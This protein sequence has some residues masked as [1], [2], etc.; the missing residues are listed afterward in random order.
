ME[1]IIRKA[2]AEDLPAILEIYND[3]IV[4]TTA[5]YDYN[6]HTLAMRQKWFEDKSVA[7][8]PVLVAIVDG[9]IAG[10]ATYGPFRAWAAYQYAVEHSVYVHQNYRRKGIAR[11]LLIQLIEAVEQ[12]GLHTLIAGIDAENEVSIQLH[13][14][15]GFS[16]VGRLNQVGYKFD[17]WLDLV[18]MQ[19]IL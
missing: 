15:L 11:K 16:V 1:I 7:N 4:N 10:F 17:R 18:F 3:A 12:Q 14:Q 6:P 5:V 9:S 19:K 2:T 8:I 13:E